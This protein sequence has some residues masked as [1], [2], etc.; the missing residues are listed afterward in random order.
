[1]K[2][3]SMQ[4]STNDESLW[5]TTIGEFCDRF[6]GTVQTGPFGSQLHASDYSED[7][8]PVVM[9]QDM[10]DGE[11]SCKNIARVSQH[12]VDRLD[13]HKLRVG[14]IV[15]S[16]RGDVS[17]FAVV[18]GREEG[19]LCGT[20][21]IR[22]RLNSP[23][24]DTRYLRRFLQ[25]ETI[26]N[27]LRHNATGVTMPNLNTEI[28]RGIPF[29][30][31]PLD[32]QRRIAA[33]L[34]QADDLRRKRRE[35]LEPLHSL[36][37][38]LLKETFGDLKKADL[39]TI[40]RLD[41]LVRQGDRINYGVVQPGSEAPRGVPLIRVENVVDD[42]FSIPKLKHISVQIEA[43]YSRSRLRGDEILVA[44]VGSIGAVALTQSAQAGFNIA[45]AVARIPIDAQKADR[46]FVAEYIKSG[47]AQNYFRSETRTVAQPTLNIKQLCETPIP[48]PPLDLQRAF[49]ARVAE[50]DALKAH[51]RA[52]LAKL[53]A[54]FTCLQHHAFR[55]EL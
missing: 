9:P 32:E 24:I 26:G 53:D 37:A 31:P 27:W 13:R 20:G 10:V 43:K 52:H 22:I 17:R 3:A 29:V 38:A 5:H 30:Y 7:G 8:V 35:G 45:R 48:I 49:A 55:G 42:D 44:C 36:P 33:I 41:T 21:S 12:H 4:A 11:V 2:A 19:W 14:D 1:V 16:R 50:I 25:Q 6:G 54:L 34:D 47:D 46:V 15:F 18:T 40:G 51:Q 28:I 23:E 39:F